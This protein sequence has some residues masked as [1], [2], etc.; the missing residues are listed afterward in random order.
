MN[1]KFHRGKHTINVRNNPHTNM[2][3]KSA[4]MRR[5]EYKCRMLKYI[6]K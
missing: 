6:R 5:A 2:L 1:E 3:S 4:I